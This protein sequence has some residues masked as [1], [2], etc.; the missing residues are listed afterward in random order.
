MKKL[1]F[2]L[3]VLVSVNAQAMD[4]FGTDNKF[5]Q[6]T[7]NQNK[8]LVKFELCSLINQ[9]CKLIGK[10][11]YAK[12]D[13]IELQASE[14]WDWLKVLALDAGIIVGSAFSG[15]TLF[16]ATIGTA[17]SAGVGT[18]LLGTFLASAAGGTAG[19]ILPAVVDALNPYEQYK[20]VETL[21]ADV[22]NDKKVIVD[23]D[24]AT[25]A[26]RLAAVL[27]NLD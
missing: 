18:T 7:E 2:V 21:D 13:L 23:F 14:E 11:F 15:G 4:V 8:T 22:L 19:A 10:G 12:K 9:E 26:K 6:V 25:F 1:F 16:Y 3:S 20:Q 24:V 27:D 17:S 5:I